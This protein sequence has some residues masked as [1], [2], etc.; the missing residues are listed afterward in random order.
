M[1]RPETRGQNP[2][3]R[4]QRTERQKYEF[5]SGLKIDFAI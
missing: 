1:Q 3:D 2:E 4:I 5:F